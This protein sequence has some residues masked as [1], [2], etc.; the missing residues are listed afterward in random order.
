MMFAYDVDDS[1]ANE[2]GEKEEEEEE[3]ERWEY[4][5]QANSPLTIEMLF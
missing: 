5:S 4:G 2:K 1:D 3:E